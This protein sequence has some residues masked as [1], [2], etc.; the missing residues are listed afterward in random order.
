MR[1]DFLFK[2]ML[3]LLCVHCVL[4]L[5]V[6]GARRRPSFEEDYTILLREVMDNLD[7][8]KNEVHIQESQ[9]STF[10]EKFKNLDDIID[11]LR[12]ETA[13]A[14]QAVKESLKNQSTAWD[15][16]LSDQHNTSKG[17]SHE[18]KSLANDNLQVLNDFKKR[19][20]EL[21]KSLDLQ[22][23]NIENLQTALSSVIEAIKGKEASAEKGEA[24]SS[25]ASSKT[26]R[27]K[28]GDSLEKIAKQHQ[29]TIKKLKEWNNLTSDQILVGQ[30]LKIPE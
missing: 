20:A 10:E 19:I 27:V 8:L 30:K 4:P 28:A 5:D 9:I 14:L 13:A 7:T 12:Q 15:A 16:K 17:L 29:T 23:R 25:E 22:N 26:Y 11:S 3:A 6:E 1:F 2:V 18:V 24:V 21:E